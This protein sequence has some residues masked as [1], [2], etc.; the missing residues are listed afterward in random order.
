[1]ASFHQIQLVL[2]ILLMSYPLYSKKG[3]GNFL[4][5]VSKCISQDVLTTDLIRKFSRRA[6]NYMLTYESLEF[7]GDDGDRQ[8]MNTI[9]N[10]RIQNL[11]KSVACHR[12]AFDFDMGFILRSVKL[13]AGLHLEHEVENGPPRRKGEGKRI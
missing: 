12:A 9:S 10:S 13:V 6:R 4:C 5:L 1:M 7:V 2:W 11:Q 8:N 3:K